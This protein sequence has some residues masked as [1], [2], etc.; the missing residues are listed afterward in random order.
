MEK[1][2]EII[3]IIHNISERTNMLGLNATIEAAR[4]G[5]KGRGFAVV[6]EEISKLAERTK[7]SITN[8]VS[9]IEESN[10]KVLSGEKANI[11]L[12]DILH[13]MKQ[14]AETEWKNAQS[15][16]NEARKHVNE[17]QE[18]DT[19]LSNIRQVTQNAFDAFK[20]FQ[21]SF[22]VIQDAI[23]EIHKATGEEKVISKK[24]VNIS[25]T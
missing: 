19:F 25:S 8:I 11:K 9:L 5:E 22:Q 6:A 16:S 3:E 2:N 24:L 21:S 17:I 12:D 10:T 7:N 1:I 13:Q 14:V 15:I 23:G 18:I 4:A 20:N